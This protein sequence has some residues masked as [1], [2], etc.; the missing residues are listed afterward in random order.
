MTSISERRAA[1][2][3][4]ITGGPI[5]VA[6]GTGDALGARLIQQAGFDAVYISGFAVEGSYGMPDVGFLGM[7]EVADRA[8]QIVDAVDLPV[9]CDGDTGYGSA[10]NV[11]RT[12]RSFERAGVAA[13]QLEDQALP[14]K[15]GSMAGKKLVSVAEMTGKIR[16]AVDTRV[17]LKDFHFLLTAL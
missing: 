13:L 3:R 17:V 11:V 16:A 12:I 5:L 9:L 7:S 2:R 1:L 4:R 8:A 6:P 14:K 10:V 15:C